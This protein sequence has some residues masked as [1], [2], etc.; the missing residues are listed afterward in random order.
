MFFSR[1]SIAQSFN[2]LAVT[3]TA[4][5]LALGASL[6]FFSVSEKE[7]NQA[8]Q[9]RY[10]SMLLADELRQSSDDLTRLGRTYVVTKDPSFKRQYMDVLAIRDGKKPR[11]KDYNRIYWDF[12]S[13]GIA[14]PNPPTV[15]VPLLELMR[16]A[17]FTQAEFDKLEQAKAN[18]DGL[19]NLEVEAMNLVEGRDKNGNPIASPDHD[20]AIQ[21]LH[22]PEYHKYKADIMVHVDEF[23]E[24]LD[25]RTEA[26]VQAS[27]TRANVFYYMTLGF[28][29]ALA[30]VLLSMA[31]LFRNRAIKGWAEVQTA[32][33]AMAQGNK[34]MAIPGLD[35]M[36]EI[37]D[38]ARA[39]EQSRS[40]TRIIIDRVANDIQSR[41]GEVVGMI[42]E[43]SRAIQTD[44]SEVQERSNDASNQTQKALDVMRSTD[45]QVQAVAAAAEEMLASV[46]EISQQ[47]GRAQ[48]FSQETVS[49]TEHTDHTVAELAD[50]ADR[51]GQVVQLISEI[52]EQTNLLALNATIEAARAG[53]AGKGFAVV[54][55]EVK[56]LA[57]QT[58]SATAEISGQISGIQNVSGKAVDAIKEIRRSIE[59]ID[60]ATNCVAV[61]VQQQSSATEEISRNCHA[62]A[63]GT[64]DVMN[65]VDEVGQV[66]QNVYAASERLQALSDNLARQASSLSSNVHEIVDDLRS[67]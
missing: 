61:A 4:V 57:A 18:S 11:P 49:Q 54:A 62:T 36:D 41:L 21:L 17:G 40:E 37:G 60:D 45:S 29:A 24:M 39:I 65:H 33:A 50:A 55:Q 38:M 27:V 19:V 43:A 8:E 51:I 64:R 22:S 25:K 23:L 35:R 59:R 31:M 56:T 32:I 67:A 46:N 63:N 53:E 7:A 10:Q 42:T 52:A 14:Q 13:A 58:A 28:S 1:F 9:N 34:N 5:V 26:E 15:A 20:R 6:F 66:Q 12:V 16:K 2:V 48:S 47:L 44:S 30:L 3:G